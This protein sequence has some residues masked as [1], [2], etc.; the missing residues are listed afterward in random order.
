M[1]YIMFKVVIYGTSYGPNMNALP[2]R[3]CFLNDITHNQLGTSIAYDD[4][5]YDDWVDS[6][7]FSSRHLKNKIALLKIAIS[8]IFR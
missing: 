5:F 1:V 4:K 3:G 6:Y 2:K 7:C 8:S